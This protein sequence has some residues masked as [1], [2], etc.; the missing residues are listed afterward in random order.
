MS[1]KLPEWANDAINE[2]CQSTA[3]RSL[4]NKMQ[5]HL[6]S[7][8]IAQTDKQIQNSPNAPNSLS[9][10]TQNNNGM[11][12]F[13]EYNELEQ[14]VLVE[15]ELRQVSR[16]APSV[17]CSHLF[18]SNISEFLYFFLSFIPRQLQL[19]GDEGLLQ[20]NEVL[21]AII[22]DKLMKLID[23]EASS[24]ASNVQQLMTTC[25]RIIISALESS[26]PQLQSTAKLFI[27]RSNVMMVSSLIFCLG[28]SR[29]ISEH[30]Y[31]LHR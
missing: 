23:N 11:K 8:L 31:G 24:K 9:F 1:L 15:Q 28:R 30:F 29:T 5:L 12:R 27:N 22:D 6:K 3:W 17:S 7:S 21:N 18:V 4:I 19:Q 13:Y 16:S 26:P 25:S 10:S 14:A 20:Y 2:S